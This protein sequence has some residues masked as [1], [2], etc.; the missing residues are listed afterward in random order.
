MLEINSDHIDSLPTR[1]DRFPFLAAALLLLFGSFRGPR[2][3]FRHWSGSCSW[4]NWLDGLLWLRHERVSVLLL[5]VCDHGGSCLKRSSRVRRCSRKT[6]GCGVRHWLLICRRRR[7]VSR[8]R[9]VCD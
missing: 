2:F 9:G 8:G 7:G 3:R 1:N 4:R 5:R 6:W